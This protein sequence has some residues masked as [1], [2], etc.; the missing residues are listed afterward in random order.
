MQLS[1]FFTATKTCPS[2]LL[3]LLL[4][5]LFQFGR[6][7]PRQPI[8]QESCSTLKSC[9]K[10]CSFDFFKLERFGFEVSCGKV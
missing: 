1:H 9:R 2:D 7:I 10:S 4:P 3:N 6:A 8:A 5:G